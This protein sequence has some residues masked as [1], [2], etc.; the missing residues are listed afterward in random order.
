MMGAQRLEVLIGKE[1]IPLELRAD[2]S[3]YVAG[4]Q[5][6]YS[7]LPISRTSMQL[8][9]NGR[10]YKVDLESSPDQVEAGETMALRVNGTPF[11]VVVNDERSKLMKS[12]HGSTDATA[13]PTTVRAP[14]PGLVSKVEVAKGDQVSP[15]QGLVI[16]EA[17]KMENE[18]R[19]NVKGQ[20]KDIFVQTGRAVEKGEPI[21][22]IG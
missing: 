12:A 6:D 21:L 18:I 5:M 7:T 13:G 14:M 22:T 1:T 17:M 20:I 3:A 11:D 4:K 15:G 16:L 19:S 8:V 10:V 9:V 2:G